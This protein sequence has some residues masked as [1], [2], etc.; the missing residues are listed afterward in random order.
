M[1]MKRRQAVSRRR[2]Q[3]LKARKGDPVTTSQVTQEGPPAF[4]AQVLEHVQ[5]GRLG[6]AV[7]L[8]KDNI[9]TDPYTAYSNL[10]SLYLL[11][12]RFEEAEDVLQKAFDL[13]QH[14]T[15]TAVGLAHAMASQQRVDQAVQVLLTSL[16]LQRESPS[17]RTLIEPLTGYQAQEAC[18]DVLKSL[19]EK[20]PDNLQIH[21][22]W[23][24]M[25]KITGRMQEAEKAFLD[26]TEKE[27]HV[28]VLFE[29]A[30]LYRETHR[31]SRAVAYLQKALALE[32][33]LTDLYHDLGHAF[34]EA[35]VADQGLAVFKQGLEKWPDHAA[36]RSSFLVH[37]HSRADATPEALF[38]GYKQWAIT[39]AQV[40][41]D[42]SHANA[43]EPD[44]VLRIGYLCPKLDEPA[45]L[46]FLEP[47]VQAHHRDRVQVY[48][49]G[50]VLNGGEISDRVK[51]H[52]DGFSDIGRLDDQAASEQIRQDHIDVLVDLTGH[53]PG[54]R[55]G[56]MALKPAPVQV[57]YLGSPDT[58]GLSQID[59]RLTDAHAESELSRQCS[60][61]SLV[62]LP[63]G[64]LCYA[65]PEDAP[66][67]TE[68]PVVKNGYVTFGSFNHQAKINRNMIALWSKILLNNAEA[69]F[70]LMLRVDGDEAVKAAF[71]KCFESYGVSAE[72][73][74][75]EC[76]VAPEDR[77]ACMGS[78]DIALDSYPYNGTVTTCDSLWMG[79]PVVTL[80]GDLHCS[81]MGQ[82]LLS[83]L[84]ME[85]LAVES[86][87][88]YVTMASALASKPEAISQMRESMRLR[89]QASTLCKADAF[90]GQLEDAYQKMWQVW[91]EKQLSPV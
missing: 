17:I 65:P 12:N 72:R 30:G 24:V 36:L 90:V 68:A 2:I 85:F 26:V 56:V 39:H 33:N 23:A 45:I 84:S 19:H 52:F 69:R 63:Q 86:A 32:P 49:Y 89:M 8:L 55:L 25:L 66:E 91:C 81:R 76:L 53:M 42:V 1:D 31:P 44:R 27:V 75:I 79:V 35:G 38:E 10:G 21:F 40:L 87:D 64:F 34:I 41:E 71:V 67:V 22:E 88:Q 62:E 59:Y 60:V 46:P 18:F 14:S 6:P 77:L 57:A 78:V 15:G 4:L 50:P 13:K 28:C 5:A 29:L 7:E 83:Q 74:D 48:G 51:G 16:N 9:Q 47:L 37:S 80:K 58:T 3:P 70:R 54:H 82:S 73:L 20:L 11:E 43:L 61:E